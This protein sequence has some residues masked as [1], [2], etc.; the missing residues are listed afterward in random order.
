M[1]CIHNGK[2]SVMVFDTINGEYVY[3][4][5]KKWAKLTKNQRKRFRVTHL[6]EE[7][8]FERAMINAR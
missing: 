2:P 1:Y 6:H 8:P 4:P 7:T 3:F 5:E